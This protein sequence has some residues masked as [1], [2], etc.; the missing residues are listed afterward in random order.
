M[1]KLI[2]LF[3][4]TAFTSFTLRAQYTLAGY[5]TSTG[6][7]SLENS[8]AAVSVSTPIYSVGGT[9]ANNQAIYTSSS[10]GQ[11]TDYDWRG[12]A[13]IEGGTPT[14]SLQI[15]GD[16]TVRNYSACGSGGGGSSTSAG[17]APAPSGWGKKIKPIIMMDLARFDQYGGGGGGMFALFDDSTNTVW[18]PW[19]QPEKYVKKGWDDFH[20]IQWHGNRGL[21]MVWDLIGDSNINDLSK[22][23]VFRD[24]VYAYD[25]TFTSGK[26]AVYLASLDSVLA[27]VPWYDRWKYFARPDSLLKPFAVVVPNNGASS[28]GVWRS[29]KTRKVDSA[30]YVYAWAVADTTGGST[31]DYPTIGELSFYGTPNFDSATIKHWSYY[32][33]PVQNNTLDKFTGVNVGGL[34]NTKNLKDRHG[35]RLYAWT[36]HVF[37]A[38]S[39]TSW[40]SNIYDAS[41]DGYNPDGDWPIIDSLRELGTKP[42]F[43]IAGGNKRQRWLTNSSATADLNKIAPLNSPLDEVED[44]A[45]YRR[46][47]DFFRHFGAKFGK[48]TAGLTA[49]QLRWNNEAPTGLGLYWFDDVENGNEEEHRTGI[50][51][52]GYFFKSQMD[53]DG[54]AGRFPN[55]GLRSSDTSMKLLMS[56]THTPDTNRVKMYVYF[57]HFFRPDS[58]FVWGSVNQHHYSTSYAKTYGYYPAQEGLVGARGVTAEYDSLKFRLKGIVENTYRFLRKPSIDIELTEWGYDHYQQPTPDPAPFIH[59][60]IQA[61]NYPGY[62]STQDKAI[63]IEAGIMEAFAAGI[64]NLV[65]FISENPC[66]CDNNNQILFATAGEIRSWTGYTAT[67]FWPTHHTQN[68]HS[69]MLTDWAWDSEIRGDA[70]DT[71]RVYK[72]RH[73]LYVDSV[74]YYVRYW[75][76]DDVGTP[77]TVNVGS[78]DGAGTRRQIQFTDTAPT[79]SYV[80]VNNGEFQ[81]TA[82]ARSQ[83][84]FFKEV[85]GEGGGPRRNFYRIRARFKN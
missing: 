23:Y 46:T 71:V 67:A 9:I 70:M 79:E 80:A 58:L 30:R 18:F 26:G 61:P 41:P 35:V 6:Q 62:D 36:L 1:K 20:K 7:G 33:P 4:L 10:G 78:V 74:C 56:A 24:S 75:P 55:L 43:V 69:R 38:D 5:I 68:W 28:G 42:Y 2:F 16:G 17:L 21:R 45:S 8:C 47:A 34:Y 31:A 51:E 85:P 57:S 84:F 60:F 29:Y 32:A 48:N 54:Y 65:I 63:A 52:L 13:L 49:G 3:L 77:I 72:L 12:F 37:D 44:P 50:S 15:W 66:F 40:P 11:I 27:N 14:H 83:Y 19:R 59:T 25:K 82:R 39:T 64:N 22:K 53:Y 81:T 73:K 76:L